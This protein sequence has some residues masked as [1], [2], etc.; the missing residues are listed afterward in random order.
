MK[1]NYANW[2]TA[3]DTSLV[4]RLKIQEEEL[5]ILIHAVTFLATCDHGWERSSSP[6]FNLAMRL[7]RD[8]LLGTLFH[9]KKLPLPSP[10]FNRNRMT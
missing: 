8:F 3:I 10:W 2:V 7:W 4:N 6:S 5:V 9:W 1:S